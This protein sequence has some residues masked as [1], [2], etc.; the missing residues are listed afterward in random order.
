MH[1]LQ[2]PQLRDDGVAKI[3][4]GWENKVRPRHDVVLEYFRAMVAATYLNQVEL[5]SL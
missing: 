2:L 4:V 3:E 5:R 1:E